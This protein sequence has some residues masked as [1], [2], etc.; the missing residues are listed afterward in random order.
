MIASPTRLETGTVGETMTPG[1]LTCLPVTPLR[2]VAQMM[3]THRV[4]AIV[5]FGHEDLL[6]PWGVVSD[7]D[8]VGAIESRAPAGA[9]AASPV[10]TVT[11]SDSLLQ[12]ASLMR[13]HS[14]SHLIVVADEASPLPIGVLSTLDIARV[15][16]A[17]SALP[18][19]WHPAGVLERSH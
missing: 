17:E 19:P 18:E 2:V 10:V 3:A 14:T 9:I 13:E 1:I 6:L 15:F 4:H 7:L 16:A 8:L 12:A 11:P 5:V